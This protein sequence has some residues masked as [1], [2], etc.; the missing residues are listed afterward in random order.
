MTGTPD[1]FG[2]TAF[3]NNIIPQGRIDPIVLRMI[4]LLPLPNLV[5]ADGSIPEQNNYFVQA[6]FIFNR[7]TVDSKVN[8]NATPKLNFFGRYSI[9]DFWQNNDTVSAI[10]CR[11]KG[12]TAAAI[13]ALAVARRTASRAA[14]PT[15][16]RRTW[17][18]TDTWGGCG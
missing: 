15:R 10:C 6:P 8:W 9:L 13:P 14:S 3:A 2:R 7:W 17:C 12:S 4:P 5:N 1:G 11:V 18:S 16:S